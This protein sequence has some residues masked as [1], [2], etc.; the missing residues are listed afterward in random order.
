MNIVKAMRDR[1]ILGFAFHM[2]SWRVWLAILAGAFGL[3]LT[4]E[5]AD[6]FRRLTGREPLL[7]AVRE[8]W[9]IAGRR[10]GKTNI[11]AAIAIYLATLK[12]WKV[13]PGEVA[14]VM[15]L[16]ADRDQA[17]VAFRYAL[18]L[19]EAS[20]V[21]ANEL[22]G[23][24][25]SDT[26]RLK[27][28]I[29][30]VIATSDKASV[31]GR[32][33]IAVIAD[34]VSFWGGEASEV[35]RAVR[36]G[37]AT[38]PNAMLIAISTAYS[39]RGPLYEA[40]KRY[41]GVADPHV[42]VV[43][44][45]TR[46][47]NSNITQEFIDAELA[48]D[49]QA[50]AAEYLAEFRSDLAAL[51]DA[52]LID[53]C[54]RSE[55]REIPYR[56]QV[57]GGSPIVYRAGVDVSGGRSDST[58][59]AIVHREGDKIIV[60]A[61]KYW[62]APHDPQKVAAE[63]SAFLGSYKLSSAAADQYGAELTKSIYADAGIALMPSELNRSEAYL[64]M[65]PLFTSGRIEIPSEPRL[66]SEL[67]GLERRTGNSGR[68]SVDHRQGQHDDLSNAVAVAAWLVAKQRQSTEST[69]KAFT[70]NINSDLDGLG[71]DDPDPRRRLYDGGVKQPLWP[72]FN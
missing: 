24:P 53:A 10:A 35:L 41:Y 3:P 42:L 34:E 47:L 70:S 18:G 72:D 38:Q 15:V 1:K 56:A 12:V 29:E 40:F 36:P 32:T 57:S 27:S 48:R 6:T 20:P 31:R 17:K 16:A 50:A 33:L 60:D 19:I 9:V 61:A 49:P 69:F 13:S 64:A 59:A 58:A 54:T 68:D 25:T 30:I 43:K 23:S 39:Q 62:P 51:L 7:S 37:M 14:T 52:A 65:Q 28:G 45:S 67:L 66:R 55:P 22:D 8:L 44:A 5:D 11:A 71:S 4:A 26:I 2:A 21:L 46:D 63:V